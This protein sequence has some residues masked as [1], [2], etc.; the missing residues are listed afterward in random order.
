MPAGGDLDMVYVQKHKAPD[1]LYSVDPETPIDPKSKP[2]ATTV[3][4]DTA[5]P[6]IVSS[7]M[8]VAPAYTASPA[9]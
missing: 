9:A 8:T 6:Q 4:L 5:L 3:V 2:Y 7:K 1:P